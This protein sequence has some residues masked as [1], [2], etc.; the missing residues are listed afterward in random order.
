MIANGYIAEVAHGDAP[1]V[2]IPSSGIAV[3]G[4]P[5]IPRKLAPHHGEHTEQVL[6]EAGYT[7]DEITALRDA[8]IICAVHDQASAAR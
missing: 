8:N 5:A 2:R 1:P 3:D 6:L 7:W 4:E